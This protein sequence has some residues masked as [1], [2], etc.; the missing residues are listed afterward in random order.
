[1][2]LHHCWIFGFQTFYG[3][4]DIIEVLM[5]LLFLTYETK[6]TIKSSPGVGEIL[7]PVKLL[8][9]STSVN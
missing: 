8:K 6:P 7:L 4:D 2:I 3:R 9:R 5:Q 1:M